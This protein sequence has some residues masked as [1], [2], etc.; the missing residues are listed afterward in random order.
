MRL[1]HAKSQPHKNGDDGV[2]ITAP[3]HLGTHYPDP[4]VV[5]GGEIAARYIMM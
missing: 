3:G 5:G 4:V 1:V 2:Q